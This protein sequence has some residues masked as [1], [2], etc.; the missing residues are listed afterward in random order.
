MDYKIYVPADTS[1]TEV[2]ITAGVYTVHADNSSYDKLPN[3][4]MIKPGDT[5]VWVPHQLPRFGD[6]VRFDGSVF[7]A[8]HTEFDP[9]ILLPVSEQQMWDDL[10]ALRPADVSPEG[11]VGWYNSLQDAWLSAVLVDNAANLITQ[12]KIDRIFINAMSRR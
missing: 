9:D 10:E 12:K 1:H 5:H 8:V 3:Q 4:A 6:E 2:E 11:Y 7:Y